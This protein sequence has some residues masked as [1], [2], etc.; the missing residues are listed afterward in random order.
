MTIKLGATCAVAALLFGGSLSAATFSGEFWDASGSLGT[1][2]QAQAVIDG[3]APDATFESTAIDYPN[4]AT[5][6]VG[7]S[8]AL[9]VF[10]GADAATLTGGGSSTL[11]YSVFRFTG[12]LDLAAGANSFSV[13]SDDGFT[14]TV[15][16]Y[17]L[18]YN[19]N[20]SFGTTSGSNDAG[21]GSTPF[22]LIYWENGGVTGV[23]FYVDGALAAPS[24][25]P[26]NIPL[27]ASLPLLVAGLSRGWA[28]LLSCVAVSGP[29][30]VWPRLR[31]AAIM[32]SFNPTAG[33]RR[34]APAL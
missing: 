30:R 19:G 9:S 24:E 25:G 2:A 5:A 17:S 10:L 21:T 28:G 22:E 12:Y 16:A 32:A 8:T 34:R 33:P 11:T 6:T 4:G 29:D 31:G 15:G 1:I 14:L 26:G 18:S 3:G 20:R 7:D 23:E 13:G 27:P